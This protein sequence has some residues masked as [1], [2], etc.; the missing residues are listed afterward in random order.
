MK[1]KNYNILDEASNL[2]PYEKMQ[3]FEAGTR[4]ENVAACSD[5]KLQGYREICLRAH[6]NN[7]LAKIEAELVKRG[8]LKT[9]TPPTPPTNNTAPTNKSFTTDKTNLNI[10]ATDLSTDVINTINQAAAGM[11]CYALEQSNDITL[12]ITYLLVAMALGK[13][14]LAAQ[15]KDVAI[16]TCNYTLEEVK[17]VIN[18][19]VSNPSIAARLQE[20]KNNK[21]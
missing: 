5:S 7:A 20:I 10:D 13:A 15:I 16:N 12:V 3:A 19:L 18:N 8:I 2:T 14:P 9:T 4:R 17:S 6:F 11:L 21:A 1:I